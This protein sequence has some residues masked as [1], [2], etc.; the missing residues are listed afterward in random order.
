MYVDF[1]QDV[2]SNDRGKRY[3]CFQRGHSHDIKI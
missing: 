3:R 2:E 1:E